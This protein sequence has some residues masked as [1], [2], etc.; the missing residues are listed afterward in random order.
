MPR[1]TLIR[2]T[3]IHF[4]GIHPDRLTCGQIARALARKT[5][6][7]EVDEAEANRILRDIVG[8]WERGEFGNGELYVRSWGAPLSSAPPLLLEMLTTCRE[9]GLEIDAE[10]S[11]DALP[12]NEALRLAQ[13]Q[14]CDPHW[15]FPLE[16]WRD[17]VIMTPAAVRRYLE[18]NA[19][20][21]G[22]RRLLE[23]LQQT[24][25]VGAPE[26][27]V[28]EATANTDTGKAKRKRPKP[29]AAELG[30]W[31][32]QHV[33]RGTKRDDA[34]QACRAETGATFR[35]ATAAWNRLPDDLK[36]K[37]GQRTGLRNIEQ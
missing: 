8:R 3:E 29:T 13:A 9:Q 20:L 21:A 30:A 35:D 25:A 36:L 15:Y 28:P 14:L 34:I 4:R 5:G 10:N 33:T 22:A 32:Q 12:L 19:A 1:L 23:E 27:S 7:M 18:Q 6:R 37:R 17:A 2:E 31:M 24:G 16:T 11:G 26:R